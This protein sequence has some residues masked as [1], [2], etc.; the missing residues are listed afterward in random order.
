MAG[1]SVA[2]DEPLTLP[3]GVVMEKTLEGFRIARRPRS[4]MAFFLVPLM[5]VWSGGSLSAI[6]GRQLVKGHFSLM[7]SRFGLPFL[8]GTIFLGAMTLMTACGGIVIEQRGEFLECFTGVGPIGFRKRARWAG[9]R[10]VREK[11]TT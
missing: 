6:Y 3:K 2:P 10:P 7:P 8:I 5:L 1:A 4:K 9:I 11:P